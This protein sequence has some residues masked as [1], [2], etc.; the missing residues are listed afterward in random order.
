MHY[1]EILTLIIFFTFAVLL[2]RGIILGHLLFKSLKKKYPSYYKSIGEPIV[3]APCNLTS[4][5]YSRLMKGS[6]F[7]NSMVFRGIPKDFPNDIG[8][9]KRAQALRI[10]FAILLIWS[11]RTVPGIK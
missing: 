2:G 10:I 8:L 6:N 11:K 5:A 3:F 1:I 7:G 9:R 4:H